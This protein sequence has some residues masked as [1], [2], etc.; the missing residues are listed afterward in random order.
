MRMA[1][2]HTAFPRD[3]FRH[4]TRKRG[5]RPMK[6][7]GLQ[8]LIPP[9]TRLRLLGSWLVVG[10]FMA[11]GAEWLG[12]PLSTTTAAVVFIV[13]FITI[14]AASFGVVREADPLAHPLGEPYG[15]I[16]RASCRERVWPYGEISA[17]ARSFK[18][19]TQ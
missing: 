12:K 5:A 9:I 1:S 16:G 10:L 18:K 3:H 14:L 6:H 2:S 11:F 4:Y 15:K 19:K 8:Q 7:S 17:V 13:L